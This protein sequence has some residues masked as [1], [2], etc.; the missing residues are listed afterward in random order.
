MSH[1]QTSN[2]SS[3]PIGLQQV[4]EW[5]RV[6]NSTSDAELSGLIQAATNRA[7][8]IM[9]RPII[10][11]EYTLKLDSLPSEICLPMVK[12]Q[13]VTSIN[14]I[15]TDGVSQ[16][17]ATNQYRVDLGGEYKQGRIV[18]AYGISWPSVRDIVETV[19]VVYQA[20]YGA[21]WNSVPADIQQAI[22]YLVSHYYDMR[23]IIGENKTIPET[24]VDILMGHRVYSV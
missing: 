1:N 10:Q 5:I 13:S 22:A 21:D 9:N 20:G 15:D 4:K 16:T 12:A 11:R 2:P 17:L 14:Y 7:E 3:Y 24:A 19:T 23:D 6:D 18:P 8:T